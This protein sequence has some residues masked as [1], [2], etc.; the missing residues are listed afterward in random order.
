MNKIWVNYII[1]EDKTKTYI[2]STV[3]I[4]RRIRQHNGLIK[5]GAKYTRNGIWTYYCVLYNM[6]FTKNNVLSYEW[7]LKHIKSNLKTKNRRKYALEKYLLKKSNKRYDHILFIN[8]KFRYLTPIVPS[9][10][11]II[12]IDEIN[13]DNIY[14]FI[15]IFKKLNYLFKK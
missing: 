15:N 9:T 2:G 4:N 14:N 1:F 11:L 6:N 8:R 12:I 13:S 5:G 7:H 10:V 3:N